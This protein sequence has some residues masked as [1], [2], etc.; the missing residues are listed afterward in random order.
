MCRS[1][2]RITGR[3][4]SIGSCAPIPR[5]AVCRRGRHDVSR[6][7]RRLRGVQYHVRLAPLLKLQSTHFRRSTAEEANTLLVC[8]RKSF[9]ANAKQVRAEAVLSVPQG[10][11]WL[12]ASELA[13]RLVSWQH[14]EVEGHDYAF[15]PTWQKWSDATE[16]W[17][18]CSIPSSP[19]T[20]RAPFHFRVCWI[21]PFARRHACGR[22]RHCRSQWRIACFWLPDSRGR[23]KWSLIGHNVKAAY[24][25]MAS[26]CNR[27]GDSTAT[28]QIV[29]ALKQAPATQA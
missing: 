23:E 1:R 25:R 5:P 14:E 16:R 19:A 17:V 20:P 22:T 7:D 24:A 29:A 11:S 6:S 28:R 2:G 26:A 4:S 21:D 10:Y 15:P 18:K 8:R 3:R 9:D 13:Y 12:A 27:F